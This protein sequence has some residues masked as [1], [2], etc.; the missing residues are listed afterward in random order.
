MGCVPLVASPRDARAWVLLPL[1]CSL[2]ALGSYTL[3]GRPGKFKRLAVD[4]I[5]TV[6][7]CSRLLIIAC[8]NN[9]YVWRF[10]IDGHAMTV[11]VMLALQLDK[12]HCY[13][14]LYSATT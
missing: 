11:C 9:Y 6:H 1:W 13:Y 2:G 7:R 14:V 12:S 10:S 4:G 8:N 5:T 3:L